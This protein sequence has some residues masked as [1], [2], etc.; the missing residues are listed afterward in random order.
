MA[1]GGMPNPTNSSNSLASALVRRI[2]VLI[3]P[4]DGVV[5]QRAMYVRDV[6]V[7]IFENA[8]PLLFKC[9]FYNFLLILRSEIIELILSL[10]KHQRYMHSHSL[11]V[12]PLISDKQPS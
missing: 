10:T 8:I 6:C 12:L 7:K 9:L 2:L 4:R 5:Y 11:G 3:F 1:Y